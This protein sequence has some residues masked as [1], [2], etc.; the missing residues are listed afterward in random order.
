M[1]LWRGTMK[2]EAGGTI[3]L[4]CLKR[5]YYFGLNMEDQSFLL[6]G[7]LENVLGKGRR[8]ARGNVAFKCPFCNH[9]KNKLEVN[10][11]ENSPS[12]GY[13]QC[14]V[15]GEK[16][17]S[18]RGLLKHMSVSREEAEQVLQYVHKGAEEEVQ[19]TRI[20]KLPEE[21]VALTDAEPNSFEAKRI[22]NYLYS[23]GLTDL[24]FI[25]YN[26]GY[27]TKGRFRDRVI[28][29]SYSENNTLNYF[30]GRSI[31]ED[32]YM[33]YMNSD[34][35]KDSII[36]NEA[37]VNWNMPVIL[38]EGVFDALALRRN[39]VPLLGKF[40]SS[41]LMKKLVESPVEDVYICLDQDALKVA[42]KN[43][44]TLMNA[45]KKV[46]LVTSPKKDPSE[47]G[48]EAMVQT[49]QKAEELTFESLIKYKLGI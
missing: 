34:A 22:K 25:R 8:T 7:A 17:R 2:K 23:R 40:I 32:A 24:D 1:L 18:I 41:A 11:N 49:L 14:W 45:G 47:S 21:F 6:L 42:V 20:T 44:E 15:C 30:I 43:C 4:E 46:Y 3:D 9:H 26:I 16:G 36:F 37:L 19:I 28:I 39:A 48:F 13:W 29:P 38:C 12:Y 10:L 27:C 31:R 33:K 5:I 35:Q